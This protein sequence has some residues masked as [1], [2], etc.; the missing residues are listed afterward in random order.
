[1]LTTPHAKIMRA[2]ESFLSEF[3]T[4][5]ALRDLREA[6]DE[7]DEAAARAVIARWVEGVAAPARGGTASL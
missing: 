4:A 7:R 1:M 3:E 5:N 6:I 2:Q